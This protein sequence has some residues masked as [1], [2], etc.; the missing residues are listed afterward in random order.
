MLMPTNGTSVEARLASRS[1][2]FSGDGVQHNGDETGEK[3]E[4][5]GQ[6]EIA[7]GRRGGK[8][9]RAAKAAEIEKERDKLKRR[10]TSAKFDEHMAT[11]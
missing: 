10:L 1:A 7:E 6:R 9:E 4:R 5:N 2:A 8:E 3:E 11:N